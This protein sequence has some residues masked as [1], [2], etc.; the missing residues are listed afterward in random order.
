MRPICFQVDRDEFRACNLVRALVGPL[1]SYV[2]VLLVYKNPIRTTNHLENS[3]FL[4]QN[5]AFSKVGD[6]GF[7]PATSAV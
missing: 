7:E 1:S 2:G 4:L 3:S 5:A 6:A